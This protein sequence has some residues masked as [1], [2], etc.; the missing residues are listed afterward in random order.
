[1][2]IHQSG[3]FSYN[4]LTGETISGS[5]HNPNSIPI[6]LISET[7][8]P[9]PPFNFSSFTNQ[10]P[11]DESSL[12]LVPNQPSSSTKSSIPKFLAS[13]AISFILVSLKSK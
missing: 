7:S 9:K 2:C 4:L 11:K 1:M 10:S 5:N 6:S 3:C 12:F 8:F 13:L